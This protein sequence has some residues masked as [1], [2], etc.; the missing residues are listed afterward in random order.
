[1]GTK[2]VR[3]R[4]RGRGRDTVLEEGGGEEKGTGI[5]GFHLLG[6]WRGRDATIPPTGKEGETLKFYL[7]GIG[8]G[9]D[10]GIPLT[11][12]VRD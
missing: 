1:M 6:K 10:T 12:K 11:G 4:E 8:K 7:P 5:P 3:Y 9:R 2:D